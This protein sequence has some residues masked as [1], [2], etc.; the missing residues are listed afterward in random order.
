MITVGVYISSQDIKNELIFNKIVLEAHA[1]LI[2][3]NWSWS[4]YEAAKEDGKLSRFVVRV[5]GGG[6]CLDVEGSDFPGRYRWTVNQWLGIDT[7]P[8]CAGGFEQAVASPA[9]AVVGHID[10]VFAFD[11]FMY[12][13]AHRICGFSKDTHDFVGWSVHQTSRDVFVFNFSEGGLRIVPRKVRRP[14]I[15]A[16]MLVS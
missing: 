8:G 2:E 13:N 16:L 9:P 3:C 6:L 7:A 15:E 4:D 12:A 10:V 5:C 11:A 1:Q 14:R